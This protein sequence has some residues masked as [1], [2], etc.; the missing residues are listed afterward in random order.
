MKIGN[1]IEEIPK[2]LKKIRS[3]EN[4]DRPKN[5]QNIDLSSSAPW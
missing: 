5:V 3:F 2:Y 4:L 1:T